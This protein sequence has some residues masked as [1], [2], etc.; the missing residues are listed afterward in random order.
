M[1]FDIDVAKSLGVVAAAKAHCSELEPIRAAVRH[2][3]DEVGGSLRAGPVFGALQFYG[4]DVL[5]LDL[6]AL[7]Q[8]IANVFGGTQAAVAAYV[9]GDEQLAADVLRNARSIVDAPTFSFRL[10]K[11]RARPMG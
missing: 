4:D 9:A 10:D 2:T 11:F 5:L 1:T 8:R 7:S 6:L 3:V